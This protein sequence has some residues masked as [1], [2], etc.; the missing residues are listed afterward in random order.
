[1]KYLDI[2]KL[3]ALGTEEF[4][5]VKPYPYYNEPLLTEQGF[6]DLL[7][8]MPPLEMFD[9]IMGKERRAGQAPHDRYSLEYTPDMPVPVPG[10]ETATTMRR[11]ASG[12]SV[13]DNAAARVRLRASP[14][15]PPASRQP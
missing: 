5:A 6:N 4:L 12:P 9:A 7:E 14:T 8:N 11:S 3:R 10:W 2:E 13:R 15:S 1:M